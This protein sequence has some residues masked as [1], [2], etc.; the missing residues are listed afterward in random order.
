MRVNV[1]K[2]VTG[3]STYMV[4]RGKSGIQKIS[5]VLWHF[6]NPLNILST[7]SMKK[8]LKVFANGRRDIPLG[9]MLEFLFFHNKMFN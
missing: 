3:T 9:K 8:F 1:C 7:L 4:F 6:W 5:S 2:I